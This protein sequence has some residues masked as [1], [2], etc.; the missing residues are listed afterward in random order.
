[1]TPL[2]TW[3]TAVRDVKQSLLERRGLHVEHIIVTSDE[4]NQKWW[5]EAAALGWLKMEREIV[6]EARHYGKW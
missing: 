1:M 3:D 6:P 5:D 4:R 2:S